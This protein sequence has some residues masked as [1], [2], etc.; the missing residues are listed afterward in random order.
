[1]F[2]RHFSGLGSGH[3]AQHLCGRPRFWQLRQFQSCFHYKLFFTMVTEHAIWQ[4]YLGTPDSLC[5]I[6]RRLNKSIL[7]CT[8]T[9]HQ[10][11]VG[12]VMW[13]RIKR[14]RKLKRFYLSRTYAYVIRRVRDGR[15]LN[16][17]TQESRLSTFPKGLTSDGS[18]EQVPP[19]EP[20]W[21]ADWQTNRRWYC[22]SPSK[23]RP[24]TSGV[25]R[26]GQAGPRL[27]KIRETKIFWMFSKLLRV[28]SAHN[29]NSVGYY[30]LYLRVGTCVGK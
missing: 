9:N 20:T 2:H 3:L 5:D 22:Q 27:H 10:S 1:M 15:R 26:G 17:W 6:R 21:F 16:N 7:Y 18:I 13:C 12:G 30:I 11:R 28:F 23:I 19:D 24:A 4:W 8:V 29:V 25:P 14:R